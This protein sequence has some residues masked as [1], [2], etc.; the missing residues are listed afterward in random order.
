MPTSIDFIYLIL[1]TIVLMVVDRIVFFPRFKAAAL[2][3]VPGARPRAYRRTAVAQWVLTAVA[4]A[5]WIA[6]A[7][8]WRE[9]GLVPPEGPRVWVSVVIVAALGMVAV[10]QSR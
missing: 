3:N 7:R 6:G 9:L 8:S 5:I 1:V 4:L 2:A 10:R